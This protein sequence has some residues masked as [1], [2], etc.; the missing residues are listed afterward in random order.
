MDNV[1]VDNQSTTADGTGAD[2]AGF[3]RFTGI[4]PGTYS[5]AVLES[6]LPAGITLADNTGDPDRDGVPS[7][8]NTYPSLPAADGKDSDIIVTYGT[9]YMGADLGFR[10]QWNRGR[11][12]LARRGRRRSSGRLANSG[13]SGVA[14]SIDNGAG[15]VINT[16]T[17]ADGF[18]FFQELSAGSW[19]ITITTPGGMSAT[20]STLAE[21]QAGIGSIGSNTAVVTVDGTGTVT[22]VDGAAIDDG[23]KVDFGFAFSG[24]HSIAGTVVVEEQGSTDGM[25]GSPS[26][27][28]VEGLTVFLYKDHGGQNIYIGSTVTDA[29]GNYSFGNLPADDYYVSMAKNL[30]ILDDTDLDDN[31]R[32]HA[33][34]VDHRQLRC[35][36]G[37][38]GSVYQTVTV[39]AAISGLDFAFVSNKNFDF[40]DLPDSYKTRL[41]SNGARHVV[42]GTP[43]L[44]L[45]SGVDTEFNGTPSTDAQA[46]DT[47]NTDDEDGVTV[48]NP[49][50][51][52]EGIAG[53]SFDVEVTG[54]GYLLAWI[55]WD[56]DGNFTGANDLVINQA[57]TTGT[58]TIS[59]DVPAGALAGGYQE[60]YARFRLF[61][62]APSVPELAFQGNASGGEV[63]DYQLQINAPQATDNTYTVVPGTI[64]TVDP[65]VDD[66]GHSAISITGII[67]PANPGTTINLTVGTPVTLTSGTVVELQSDGTLDVTQS[68]SVTSV[69]RFDYI[70]TD[71]NGG[72][73]QAT[74]TLLA[75]HDADTIANIDDIDDDND[76]VLD[77]DE[78]QTGYRLRY[79]ELQGFDE[80]FAPFPTTSSS[81]T[82]SYRP[83]VTETIY[84]SSGLRIA[85]GAADI[86]TV[87]KTSSESFT[88]TEGTLT[89]SNLYL[90]DS[91]P[92]AAA[93]GGFY[94][95]ETILGIPAGTTTLSIRLNGVNTIF[96]LQALFVAHDGSNVPSD[97]ARDL[98]FVGEALNRLSASEPDPEIALNVSG[99][100]AVRVAFT[101]QD[102]QSNSIAGLQWNIDG[103]GWVD[104][105]VS[106]TYY[107]H[108]SDGDGKF[109]HLDIDKDNDGITDNVESQTTGGYIAPSGTGAAMIDA[110]NDGLDDNYDV[111]A[112]TPGFKPDGLGLAEVDT[113]MDGTVDTLDSDSDSDGVDDVA[114]R[115]DGQQTTTPSGPTYND[116]DGDGL[117]DKFEGSS[118]TDGFEVNDENII[119]D[120]GGADGE[121]HRFGLNDTDADTNAN[122]GTTPR[123]SN[124]ATPLASD[125]DFRDNSVEW[126]ITGPGSVNEGDTTTVYTISLD[127]TMD[128]NETA[129]II[130]DFTD[131]STAA[132]DLGAVTANRAELLAAIKTI[133]DG[134]ADLTFNDTTGKLTFTAQSVGDSM[135]DITFTLT[136]TEDSVIEADEQFTV[137][138]TTPTS[139]TGANVDLDSANDEVQTT[140]TDDDSGLVSIAATTNGD[141]DRPVDGVFTVNLKDS[142]GNAI[143]SSTATTI[144]YTVSGTSSEGDDFATIAT[145]TVTIPA[146][147]SSAT[148]TI[149]VTDDTRIEGTETVTVTLNSISSGDSDITIDSSNDDATINIADNDS[150]EWSITG[151]GSVTEGDTTTNYTISLS[152]SF[153]NSETAEIIIDF[154]DDSTAA[155][156][157][158]AVTANKDEL[159]AAIKT[160]ADGRTDLTFND[161]TGKLTFTRAECWR[162]DG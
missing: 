31:G 157:L 93:T 86:D 62:K 130:I 146:G 10:T 154:T 80:R 115:G 66:T 152:G 151:P 73:A 41:Q 126:S 64:E 19:T 48:L 94:L 138:L 123:T 88:T 141:E 156:D 109:D 119:G 61:D 69:E 32:R 4:E 65:A 132:N 1:V 56:N 103:A 11:L 116:A 43:T 6:S 97:G 120:D 159:L 98:K 35:A 149:D 68:S 87:I 90:T 124:D 100:G 52:S 21:L 155:N 148:I 40:G 46:D 95:V 70:I 13:L 108:D 144:T 91:E 82:P 153:D 85:P 137:L 54:S 101:L 51:W 79:W 83:E 37:T 133:A 134:R 158:G 49:H 23:L 102:G 161:T 111:A 24:P 74:I 84:G 15:T 139:T 145:K 140:I 58:H 53:G 20:T 22:H 117:L 89:T 14:V 136:A 104:V 44:Y 112:G 12:H 26:D 162:H 107:G 147:S 122:E 81:T 67:D 42:P 78:L 18:Y 92:I 38:G 96:D 27:V 50:N 72:T 47:A 63:E 7:W 118:T 5:V 110:N 77:L 121:Y 99:K 143:T 75:D 131:N 60:F 29:N 105:P 76:G 106:A 25:S 16:T 34:F 28:P 114:E 125:L 59:V 8:D 150:A 17:D 129:E 71:A 135:A 113:D 39:G 2:P 30:P 45:G 33:C 36:G 128:I 9:A 3:Y 127:G 160:I 55:D 142:G 57:V